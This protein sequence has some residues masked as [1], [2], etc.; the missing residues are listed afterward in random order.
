MPMNRALLKKWVPVEVLPI[1]GIV[2]IAVVGASAYLYK[3]SQ[4]PEVVWDRSSDWRPWDKVQHDQNLKLLS[5]N[6]DFW[7]KRKEQA[8]ETL[9]LKS[10]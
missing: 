3:L 8:K 5:Y 9:G 10:E 7:Q 6:P 2:G 4:G 1:F